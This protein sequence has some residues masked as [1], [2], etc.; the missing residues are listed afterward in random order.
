MSFYISLRNPFRGLRLRPPAPALL[1]AVV[2]SLAVSGCAERNKPAVGDPQLAAYVALV[3]PARIEVQRFLTKPVSFADNGSADGLEVILAAYDA[4]D[5]LTKAAGAFQFELS[6]R[7]RG[8]TLG[9]R[10]DFWA[11]EINTEKALGEYRDSLS[12][13]YRF[14]LLLKEKPLPPGDYVLSV[15][16]QLPADKRLAA[17]YAFNYDGRGAPPAGL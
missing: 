7:K 9:T 4:A 10:L 6:T 1:A 17:E 8:E 13:Y 14:P 12:R 2:V 16:L 15:S 5:E 11:V 3:M